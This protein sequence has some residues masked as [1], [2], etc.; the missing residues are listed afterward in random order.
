MILLILLT[1][2][3]S[4]PWIFAYFNIPI[5]DVPILNHIFLAV[6]LGEHHGL[7]GFRYVLPLLLLY[8][9]FR[10]F[11]D[12]G[13]RSAVVLSTSP[14]FAYRLYL[15][16]QDFWFE[17]IVKRGWINLK[18]PDPT[19]VN[20]MPATYSIGAVIGVLAFIYLLR[21]RGKNG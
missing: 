19:Q 16:V 10:W 15:L 8:F 3:I 20:V 6:H 12:L 2:F 17:Q 11:K 18:L 21:M 7:S 1:T 4:L 5:I 14:F 13:F 9:S